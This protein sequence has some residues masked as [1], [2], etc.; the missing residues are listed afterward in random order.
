VYHK[1]GQLRHVVYPIYHT[2]CAFEAEQKLRNN[3]ALAT[4]HRRSACDLFPFTLSRSMQN[5]WP[6]CSES[7]E[8]THTQKINMIHPSIQFW[9]NLLSSFIPNSS[10]WF[11]FLPIP[12]AAQSKAEVCDR[13][14]ADILGSNPTG[15]IDVCLLWVLCCQTDHSSGGD[16][17][18]VVCPMSAIVKPRKTRTRL[19]TGSKRKKK[20]KRFYS[21]FPR[22]PK[23]TW[24]FH[25]HVIQCR[26]K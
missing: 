23:A 5:I 2:D 9:L 4:G 11:Y 17:P 19:G 3:F 12:V 14:P 8:S 21:F 25:L 13:S 22:S 10:M 1:N 24:L 26:K 20:K 16:L 7:R 15:G 18:S 6:F